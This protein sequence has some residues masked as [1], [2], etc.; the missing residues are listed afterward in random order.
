MQASRTSR[1]PAG[2]PA[3]SRK[4]LRVTA[5]REDQD[6][7]GRKF[8]R[9]KQ[10]E[11]SQDAKVCSSRCCSCSNC[12]TAESAASPALLLLGHIFQRLCGPIVLFVAVTCLSTCGLQRLK[13]WC[14]SKHRLPPVVFAAATC[15]KLKLSLQPPGSGIYSNHMVSSF[16]AAD[17]DFAHYLCCR[18][19]AVSS[20]ATPTM[21]VWQQSRHSRGDSSASRNVSI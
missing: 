21:H 10:A 14:C 4:S 8:G 19:R 1:T 6:R 9:E 11:L 3:L 12:S 15:P 5:Y 20:S 16:S 18:A 7:F 2:L 17:T 13:A